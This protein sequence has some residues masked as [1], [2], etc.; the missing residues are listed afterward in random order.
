MTTTVTITGSGTPIMR[1]GQAGAGVLVSSDDVLIRVDV[2]RGTSMR[3]TDLG[4]ALSDLT[5]VCVTHHHSDHLVGLA[6]LL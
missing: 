1:P 3:L 4:V 5:A 6:D 2:G